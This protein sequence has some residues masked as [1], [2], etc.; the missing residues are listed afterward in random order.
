LK[1]AES[2]PEKGREWKEEGTRE[3]K[4][5]IERKYAQ[6]ISNSQDKRRSLTPF[7]YL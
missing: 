2:L 1:Q 6:E 5:K 4:Q 7:I 3:S